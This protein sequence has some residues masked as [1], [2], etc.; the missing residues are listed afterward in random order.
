VLPPPPEP[1]S[2]AQANDEEMSR[3]ALAQRNTPRWMLAIE[4]AD[5]TFPKAA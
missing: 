1:G 4:D 3:S 5:L 2:A